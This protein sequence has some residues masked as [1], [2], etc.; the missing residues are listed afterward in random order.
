MPNRIIDL[1]RMKLTPSNRKLVIIGDGACG[2]TSLLSVFTLGYFPTVCKSS[3][4]FRT[5]WLT[6]DAAIRSDGFRELRHRLPSRWEV[7][8]ASAMG[9]SRPRRLRAPTT[10][11]IQPSTC[12]PHS[13]LR[14]ESRLIA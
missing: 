11:S 3:V 2:K 7:S 8:T 4:L 6:K 9:Y 5:Q 13:I 14:L 1:S 10:F 12:H